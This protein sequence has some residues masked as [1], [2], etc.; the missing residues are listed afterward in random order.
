MI[1]EPSLITDVSSRRSEAKCL[2]GGR[3]GR[4]ERRPIFGGKELGLSQVF[5]L[6]CSGFGNL[7]LR[8]D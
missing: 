1:S 4:S 3:G 5:W 7:P 8:E 2:A 6:D